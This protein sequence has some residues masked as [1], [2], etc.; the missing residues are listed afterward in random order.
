MNRTVSSSTNRLL[1]FDMVRNLAMLSVVLY[2][3]VAAYSTITPH[4]SV[5]DGSSTIADMIRQLFDVFMMPVFFF[6]AGYFA[7]PSLMKQGTWKFLK[8]KF[9]R[10]GVPWLLA[11]LI[12]VPLLQHVLQKK[13]D[14]G[15]S[16][17]PFWQYWIAYIKSIGGFQI[18]P[19]T[20]ERVSQ[21]HFWFLSLLITFFIALGLFEA[22]RN[23]GIGPSDSPPIKS[24]ASNKSILKAFLTVAVLTSLGYF[25]VILFTPDMSWITIA[26]L[27]QFQPG[28]LVSFIACF[29]L[30]VFAYSRQWFGGNEF[31]RRL[32]I[33]VPI[34]VLL[35]VG[36]FNIGQDV[37]AHPL[38]SHHLP[39]GHLLAF[40][41]IRTLVC[42]VF[43]VIFIAYARKYWNRPSRFNQNLAVNSYNMYLSHIFFVVFLQ[44]VLMIWPEGPALAK[45][46]IVFLVALPISYII[47]RLIDRFP[48]GFVI[49]FIVLF[50]FAFIARR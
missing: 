23:K 18:G 25:I 10:L 27:W 14:V 19:Y 24:P 1:F 22:M 9:R 8:G 44:D 40:S 15:H 26:L 20:A 43:L 38:T 2:H 11:I 34:G 46:A 28:S 35:T 50:V 29:I 4:W 31:P 45:A 5:H 7:L 49:G 21:M 33:W 12:I 30:G 47:S 37:F 32:F 42:L 36:F 6:V 16:V 17:P 39:P 41:F 3:A 13:A 48:R